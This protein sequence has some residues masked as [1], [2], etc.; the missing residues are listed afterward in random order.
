MIGPTIEELNI[1]ATGQRTG[2]PGMIKR[3]SLISAFSA[4]SFPRFC[5]L[6][7]MSVEPKAACCMRYVGVFEFILAAGRAADHEQ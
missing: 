4:V 7:R 2:P 5:L 1:R 6:Q 3:D